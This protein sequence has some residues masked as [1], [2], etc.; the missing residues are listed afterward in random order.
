MSDQTIRLTTAQAIIRYLDN[1]FIEIDGEELRVCGGGFGIFGHGNVTCLGEA[2]YNVQDTLPL[3][4]GQNEQGMG[5]AAAAYAKQWLRRRFMFCTASAGPGTA[6]LLTSA[7]LA[8]AN[9]LPMLMLCGDAFLTRLPD[10]VLQQLEHFGNPTLGVNDAFK[11][12]SRYWDRITHPAQVIQSLPAAFATM[13]DP[14]DCGPAFIGL[15]QDVQGWAYD[16]PIAFFEK[17]VHRIRKQAPDMEEVVDAFALLQTAKRPM[18]IAGGGVQYSGAVAELTAFAEDS[19]I[20]VV[21]TIAGRANMKSDHPLNCGPIGVTGSDSANAIAEKA[22]V[23]IAVGTRLQD[24][25]TGS[26]T[27]FAKDAKIIGINVGRHDAMKHMSLP[28]VGDAAI[29]LASLAGDYKA[30]AD[31]TAFAQGERAKW[32]VYVA[33]NV[34]PGNHANSYAQAIGVVND[35]CDPRDRIVAAAGGLPAEITA[36]WRTLDIGTVDVEFGFSCMGYEIAGGWGA[37]IAQSQREPDKDTIVF[38]GDGSYLLMNSDIYSSVLTGKKLI[39]LVLDNGGFAVINKLQNNTGNE[40]FNNLIADTPTATPFTVDFEAHAASM[41]ANAETVA[42]P[43]ELA[44]A[45]KRAKASDKTTVIVMKVDAYDGWT[46][47]GH[48]WWEVGTPEVSDSP[49]VRDAHTDWESSR[50]KQR[51]GL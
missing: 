3:Y 35:L 23:I 37:R 5:F 10:P 17:R 51:K 49:K 21:E 9:R 14:A 38:T 41:G 20:P 12:V 27:A 44:E 25:T 46:T 50:P 24:F 15:P 47:E 7:A 4:R 8:H 6:N 28:V 43:A 36:N 19:G 22:D 11:A 1:Q 30:P 29:C 40:S 39:I 16:Y 42:N 31:W 13:L 26:W 18:I 45:F 34:K 2:L 33:E 32:D 48:A